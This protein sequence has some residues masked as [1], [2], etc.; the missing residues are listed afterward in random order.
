VKEGSTVRVWLSAGRRP[1]T[2][3]QLAGDQF[4]SAKEQLVQRGLTVDEHIGPAPGV[5]AG[6]VTSQSPA[7]GARLAPPKA[8]TLNVAEVPQW[9]ELTSL[10]GSSQPNSTSFRVRG[11]QWRVVYTMSYQGTCAFIFWCSGPQ[12]EVDNIGSGTTVA[13]FALNNG[14]RQTRVFTTGPGTYRL[15]V[16]PGSDS[17]GWQAYIADYY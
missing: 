5:P 14:G 10:D 13:V 16:S 8:V 12:A 17:A 11:S 7:P 6:T 9:R 1:V 3:P 2:V 15:S 4:A